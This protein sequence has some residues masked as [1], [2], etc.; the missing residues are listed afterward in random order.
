MKMVGKQVAAARLAKNL[1]Q[2]QLADLI[3]VDEESIASIEQGRRMLM[4]NVAELLDLHL[5][6]P[7]M[8]T[9]AAVEMPAKDDLL[10]WAE[11]FFDLEKHAIA[12]NWFETMVIPGILQTENHMR[13]LFRCRVPVFSPE[14]MERLTARRLARLQILHRKEPPN[15]SF[16]IWEAAL[17]DRIGGD[18]VHR[19]QLRH[20][21]DCMEIPHV[22]IQVLPLGQTCQAGLAGPFTVL[23]TPDHMLAGYLECQ[24]TSKLVTD[25]YEVSLLAQRYAMLR[26]Q[27]LNPQDTRR[28]LERLL[29]EP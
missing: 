18:A 7:G 17:L 19:E 25:P 22:T 16:V 15:L 24:R 20:L 8:L 11:G 4:P 28:L 21:V 27:A 23:E 29:G 9:V 1:T 6:L 2:R 5:G 26:T 13:A 3:N 10:P 12:L 14:E